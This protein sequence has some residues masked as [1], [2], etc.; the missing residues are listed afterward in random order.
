[1]NVNSGPDH[2][3]PMDRL[4]H[5]GDKT[6]SPTSQSFGH[7]GREESDMEIDVLTKLASKYVIEGESQNTICST[8]AE[9]CSL[10]SLGMISRMTR[11]RYRSRFSMGKLERV[12]FGYS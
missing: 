9:V 1:V 8:N 3:R 10:P 11:T 7:W 6:Y 4:K 5:L 12:K 2:R